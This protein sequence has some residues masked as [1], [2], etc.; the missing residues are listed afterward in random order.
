MATYSTNITV[1]FNGTLASE[2][3]GL[4]WNYGGGLP[5]GRSAVWTDDLGEVTVDLLS[6]VS[7]NSYGVRA[8]LVIAGGGMNLTC[9]A[10]CTAVGASAEIN[11]VTKYS[12]TFKITDG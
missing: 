11:G 6:P 9:M 7:T 3:V 4:S 12:A 8:S 10:I 1:T 5:R 2:V